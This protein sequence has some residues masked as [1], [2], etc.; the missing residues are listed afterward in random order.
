MNIPNLALF[1][2]EQEARALLSRLERVQS[3][4]LT[5]T[6]VCAAAISPSALRAIE[7]HLIRVKRLLRDG[8]LEFI[9]LIQQAAFAPAEAQ[10][11]FT[12]LRL[13]F[14][15]ILTQLDIFADALSQ[16][17][18]TPNGVWLAGLDVAASDALRINADLPVPPLVCYLDRGHGAAIRRARTRLPGGDENPVAIIRIPRERMI[19]SGIASSLVHEVGH[20]GNELLGLI[21]SIKPILEAVRRRQ[22]VDARVWNCWQRW[23]SE[24]LA[25]FWSVAK[26]GIAS[27]LGLMAV[28]T[29]PRYFVFRVSINDPHPTPWI[30]VKLSCAIGQA[31]YPHSQWQELCALWE[32]LYPATNLPAAQRLWLW[33]LEQ[34]IPLLVGLLTQQRPAALK[35]K[36]LVEA[37]GVVERQ[38][39]YLQSIFSSIKPQDLQHLSPSLAFALLGQAR[40][41]GQLSPEQESRLVNRLLTHWALHRALEPR[42]TASNTKKGDR[43]GQFYLQ[44]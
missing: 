8:L 24:I 18:E 9:D 1:W 39:S 2:L 16:R 44:N 43:Y 20:Q 4:S 41:D 26:L 10:R 33:Q 13:R 32:S 30:R 36:T 34:Q 3:F 5:E 14:N 6:M 19:G 23:I 7:L 27:S 37:L 38:P 28:V 40:W 17:S 15:A 12:M 35:G 29:L 21:P 42:T 22:E 25:D 31:L 11:R